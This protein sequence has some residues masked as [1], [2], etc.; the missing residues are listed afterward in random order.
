MKFLLS[1][2]NT[3]GVR[4]R[5]DGPAE[6]QMCIS[7]LAENLFNN[8]VYDTFAGRV[9]AFNS[10]KQFKKFLGWRAIFNQ[11]RP[12]NKFNFMRLARNAAKEVRFILNNDVRRVDC[13]F[14]VAGRVSEDRLAAT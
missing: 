8:R 9:I 1:E 13:N 10:L 11:H 4:V 7:N 5:L 2:N 6:E 12:N 3:D 14:S